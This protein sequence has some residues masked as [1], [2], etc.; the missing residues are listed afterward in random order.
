MA[1]NIN[2]YSHFLLKPR[3]STAMD[4]LTSFSCL[5]EYKICD[6]FNCM[7]LC[8]NAVYSTALNCNWKIWQLMRFPSEAF[9]KI[10]GKSSADALNSPQTGSFKILLLPLGIK[11]NTSQNQKWKNVEVWFCA[12]LLSFLFLGCTKTQQKIRN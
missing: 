7:H 9:S 12:H 5:L 3:F 10:L 4:R 2:I 8:K 1:N 11:L 6:L